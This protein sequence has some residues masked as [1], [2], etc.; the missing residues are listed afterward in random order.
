MSSCDFSH[1]LYACH[2]RLSLF[3]SQ[4]H[5]EPDHPLGHIILE[6]ANEGNPRC[7]RS[8]RSEAPGCRQGHRW[9]RDRYLV[10]RELAPT[11]EVAKK[12][13]IGHATTSLAEVNSSRA[14]AIFE[15]S[16]G[17]ARAGPASSGVADRRWLLRGDRLRI[18]APSRAS[19]GGDR[20]HLL[21]QH[22]EECTR[23]RHH[24]AAAPAQI[25]RQIPGFRPVSSAAFP[26]G[27]C[28]PK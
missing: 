13:G 19:G 2:V 16:R 8:I 22:V 25:V 24:A 26:F 17:S 12:Y 5:P 14:T 28:C 15:R 3:N 21:Q 1:A 6:N 18:P 7:R 27:V 9:H 10:G 20:T 23:R 11:R 4:N